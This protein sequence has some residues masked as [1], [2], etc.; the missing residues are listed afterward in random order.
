MKKLNLKNQVSNDDEKLISLLKTSTTQEPSDQFTENTMEKF[1]KASS[2]KE[3]I[4]QPL[5]LPLYMMLVIGI[6]LLTPVF[7]TLDPQL[8]L[9][10][11]GYELE[12]L[13]DNISF[14]LENWYIL[15]PLILSLILISVAWIELGWIKLRSPFI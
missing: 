8:P 14:Q 3:I 12:N 2:K 10:N 5:K 7:L 9:P 13:I 11:L 4:Y 6:I 15:Y 1:L